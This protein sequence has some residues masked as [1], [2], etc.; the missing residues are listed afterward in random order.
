MLIPTVERDTLAA[1]TAFAAVASVCRGS[2]SSAGA[3]LPLMLMMLGLLSRERVH[4]GRGIRSGLVAAFAAA[5]SAVFAGT[6]V[7]ACI[8]G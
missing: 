5:A 4:R 7:P 2:S 1:R 8:R 3:T 6:S